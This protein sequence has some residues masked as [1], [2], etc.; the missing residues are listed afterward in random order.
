MGEFTLP[1]ML[2]AIG[3]LASVV[4][5]MTIVASLPP[6]CRRGSSGSQRGEPKA[7]T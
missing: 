2:Q 5:T 3:Q 7:M 6:A 1:R 4:L